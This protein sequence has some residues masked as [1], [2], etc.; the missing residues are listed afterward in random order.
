M[1]FFKKYG[2]LLIFIASIIFGLYIS[3]DQYYYSAYQFVYWIFC[4]LLGILFVVSRIY[5][6]PIGRSQAIMLSII[7][8]AYFFSWYIIPH[9]LRFGVFL[10]ATLSYLY[11]GLVLYNSDNKIQRW[12][13]VP[14]L[15]FSSINIVSLLY[16]IAEHSKISR[17]IINTLFI[18][19]DNESK[20]YLSG[21]LGYGHL[22][23]VLILVGGIYVLLNPK[24]RVTRGPGVNKFVLPVMLLG[25][26]LST[27]SGPVGALTTEYLLHLK[28]KATLKKMVED[29]TKGLSQNPFQIQDHQ[30][31]ARKVMIIL[32][33]SLN[34]EYMGIYGY[35]RETSPHL[36]ALE[37]DTSQGRLFKLWDMISPEANTVPALKKVLTNINNENNI[38]FQNSVTILDLFNKGEYTSFWLSNQ[39]PLGKYDTPNAVISATAD[40]RYFTAS[41]NSLKNAESASGN[42]YDHELID[43]FKA[44]T[45]S[46]DQE[47]QVFFV[48]LMGSHWFYNDRYPKDFEAFKSN[49]VNDL[50]SYLN[51]VAYNDFVVSQLIK[52]ARERGFDLICYLSDHGEDMKY[53]HNQENYR[54]GMSTIPFLV[55]LSPGY[56]DRQPTLARQLVRAGR[57]PAMTDNFFHDIQVLSGFESTLFDPS[58]S[59]LMKDY[60]VKKRR[61]VGNKILFDR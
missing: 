20:E 16:F 12:L 13:F 50:N 23:V 42:Y 24:N 1:Q 32:G 30:G 5:L 35:P 10:F 28:S 38:A 53:Q 57:I 61:V 6:Q 2:L 14:L 17:A 39:A 36:R 9:F 45:D 34:R 25:F 40:H 3:I 21:K 59:F 33:E 51:T 8:A 29:R 31:A 15:I 43:I 55:Y 47:K 22:F 7:I 27:F 26:A 44:Y 58:A 41:R 48:H 56:M 49:K 4:G 54:R 60:K 37:A 46:S 18:T 19:N 52:T 11:A